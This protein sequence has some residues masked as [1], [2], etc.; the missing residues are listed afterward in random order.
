VRGEA[1]PEATVTVNENP[2]FRLGSYYFGS[3]LFD[4]TTAGGLANLETYATLA[5]TAANGDE[6]EDLV[7]AT[8]NQVYLAQS[9]ET[10]AYDDDGNQTL[11]TTKTGLW[12]VTY[13]GENRPVRWERI[14]QSNNPNNR[15]ILRMTYDHMGRRREKNDQRFFYDGFVQ[16]A[17]HHST[18]TT[19]S[20]NYFVWDCTESIATRPLVWRNSALD[21]SHSALYYA[22][23]GNKN[24]S[25]IIGTNG[26]E[27]S[28]YE[29]TLGGAIVVLRGNNSFENPW[30]YSSEYSDDFCGMIYYNYRHYE[31]F[32]GRWLCPDPLVESG[33]NL[34]V[35]CSNSN[36]NHLDS[37]GL[38]CVKTGGAGLSESLEGAVYNG[39][40]VS[41]AITLSGMIY[42]CCCAGKLDRSHTAYDVSLSVTASFGVGI[43]GKV[44]IPLLGEVSALIKGPQITW[45]FPSVSFSKDCDDTNPSWVVT[46][47][48]VSGDIGGTMSI[49]MGPGIAV[50]YW[51]RYTLQV[52]VEFA[53]NS[54]AVVRH[55]WILGGVLNFDFGVVNL[56][57]EFAR[58]DFTKELK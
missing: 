55:G 58:F 23:D 24:V 48:G 15:T 41:G 4:N 33:E 27:E 50:G 12:R 36:L 30:R 40:G 26:N 35:W 5:Q 13:N 25:E 21:T 18:T 54:L 1:A 46:L 29:Y 3:D 47:G 20:C 8:T 6:S 39:L 52:D 53:D 10:F 31:P 34:Y 51:L 17:N 38:K 49:G 42:D 28:H 22:H 43:G 45:T 56:D 32:C 37:L 14:Q 2:T 57:G 16:I 7:S 19:S 44:K 9:P 11:I